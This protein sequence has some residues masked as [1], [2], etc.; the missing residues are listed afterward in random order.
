MPQRPNKL[1]EFWQELKRRKVTRVITVYAAAAFVILELVDIISEPFGLPDWTMKLVVVLLSIGL[2]IS[3][4]LSWIYDIH[5]EEGIVKTEPV[6][7]AKEEDVPVSSNSWKIASYFS[8]V[9]IV[10]LIVLNIIPRS[11]RSEIKEILD[12]SIAVLPFQNDSPDEE[13]EHVIN[14]YMTAI[15]DNLCKIGDLK[16]TGRTSIENYRDTPM[17]YTNIARELKVNYLLIAY[18]QK[19]GNSIRLTVQLMDAH[20]RVIWS[21]PYDSRIT[22]VDDHIALQSEIAQ[23]VASELQ[24]I[25]KPEEAQRIEKVPTHSLSAYDYFQLGQEYLFTSSEDDFWRAIEYF[26]LAIESDSMYALPY[27][28]ISLAYNH[29]SGFAILSQ[30]ESYNK[31][32]SFAEKALELDEE[33]DLI[34]CVAGNVKFLYEYDFAGA[35]REYIRAIEINPNSVLAHKYLGYLLSYMG[36]HEEAISYV[37]HALELDP[38][39]ASFK[40]S[41][42]IILN[43]AGQTEEA[44]KV[45]EESL[46]LYPEHQNLYYWCAKYYTEKGRY[47]EALSMLETLIQMME[48]DNINDE[49]AFSGYIY[50]KAGQKE[51]ALQ[52]KKQ[53]DDLASEGY[54]IAPRNQVWVYLGIDDIEKAMDILKEAYRNRSIDPRFLQGFPLDEF[55]DHPSVNEFLKEAGYD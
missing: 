45:I 27:A 32:K 7:T 2:I 39:S 23:L 53:L 11:S 13:N 51:K 24:A 15:I 21:N 33:S 48:G 18:G 43:K 34:H 37:R 36:K 25:I 52:S 49:I 30:E 9:V 14:G 50:G 55:R 12:K 22:R 4:I 47:D 17:N 5:P 41:L 19:Y 46:Q 16:V 8:F 35:E 6:H 31:A 29:L 10:G 3:I 20:E 40:V 42:S 28:G 54:Y 38:L 44:L 1:S 26:E